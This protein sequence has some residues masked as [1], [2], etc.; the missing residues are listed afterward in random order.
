MA[1]KFGLYG[2]GNLGLSLAAAL[3]NTGEDF[4][5]VC[6]IDPA[7]ARKGA[8]VLKCPVVNASSLARDANVLLFAVPDDRIATLYEE[9]ADYIASDALLV[10]FS[11]VLTSE[12]F[13]TPLR[14]SAHPA[15]TFPHPRLEKEVFKDVYFAVE[16][17]DQA[18][19]F[20]QPL[21]EKIGAN[22]FVISAQ[23][24]QL[25][26][27]MCVFASNLLI[28]LLKSAEDIGALLG[29]SEEE[30][31]GSILR[32]ARETIN[33]AAEGESFDDALSGPVSRGDT[34]TVQK[35]IES[36]EG[37]PAQQ[38]L[39]AALSLRLLEIARQ[40]GLPEE[41]IRAL[42]KLLL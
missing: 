26:H 19:A 18:K 13:T 23:D 31:R 25:Y 10:H 38:K 22:A 14:L 21:L 35:N 33:N 15:Q 40:K 41:R 7:A 28:A 29:L 36:L 12:V 30:R 34:E 20:F 39:Y 16:G 1:L 32:L 5:G 37:L 24:K 17:T 6:D 11:G 42:E 2:A 9:L 4:V 3:R 27:S 8:D